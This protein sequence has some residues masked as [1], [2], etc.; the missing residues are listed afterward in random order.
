MAKQKKTFSRGFFAAVRKELKS[1]G[2]TAKETTSVI[3]GFGENL[4]AEIKAKIDAKKPVQGLLIKDFVLSPWKGRR[5]IFF[6]IAEKLLV[7][8]MTKARL[9]ELQRVLYISQES[10]GKFPLQLV[11]HNFQD[12]IT[13]KRVLKLLERPDATLGVPQNRIEQIL[14]G[15]SKKMQN[16]RKKLG[17]SIYFPLLG[18]D[19]KI[20]FLHITKVGGI[21]Y[22]KV[23]AGTDPDFPLKLDAYIVVSGL[24]QSINT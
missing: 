15:E 10:G 18:K 3:T 20:R 14:L 13:A 22:G 5:N 17:N 16:L 9:V 8:E 12:D 7:G 24:D 4:L 19:K 2:L 6:L 11:S 21:Y 23:V 1:W